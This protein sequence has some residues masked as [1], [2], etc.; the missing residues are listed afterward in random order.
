[1]K[2]GV[3]T[4]EMT[5]PNKDD[6]ITNLRKQGIIPTSISEKAPSKSLFRRGEKITDKDMVVFTRQFATMFGA[7]IPI[8][9][10][11]DILSKQLDNKA[12]KEIIG[13]VKSD[14]ETGATLADAL[15]DTQRSST[16][17]SSTLWQPVKRAAC[18]IP[19]SCVSPCTSKRR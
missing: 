13:Q 3:Q 17:S 11:L 8:V 4:G 6:V 5:A 9:E 12:L 14:V 19:S 16:T 10:G 2:G 18:S 1:M 15:S 7:G